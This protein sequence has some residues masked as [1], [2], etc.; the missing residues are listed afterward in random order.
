MV[1][2]FGALCTLEWWII[3]AWVAKKDRAR[4]EW[5]DDLILM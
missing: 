4:A 2:V 3:W 1:V 5:V